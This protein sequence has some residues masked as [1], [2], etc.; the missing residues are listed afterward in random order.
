MK[1][2]CLLGRVEMEML[3]LR[4]ARL[5]RGPPGRTLAEEPSAPTEPRVWAALTGLG[6]CSQ[7]LSSAAFSQG[8]HA[9]VL[10]VPTHPLPPLGPPHT[11]LPR[12]PDPASPRLTPPGPPAPRQRVHSSAWLL[13]PRCSCCPAG[14]PQTLQAAFPPGLVPP[15]PEPGFLWK[16]IPVP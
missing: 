3:R 11:S 14:G 10:H 1:T 12:R 2:G 15:A 7:P 6:G 8:L 13:D 5:P 16:L 9:P 4:A